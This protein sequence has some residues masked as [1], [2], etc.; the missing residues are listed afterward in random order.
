[1][2]WEIQYKQSFNGW[3]NTSPF[4]RDPWVG[5]DIPPGE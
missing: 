1:M 2:A 3:R 5:Q 4:L